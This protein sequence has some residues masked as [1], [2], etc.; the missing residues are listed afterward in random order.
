MEPQMN[1][2]DPTKVKVQ[3]SLNHNATF[4]SAAFEPDTGR[5]LAGGDDNAIHVFDPAD[6][7]KAAGKWTKHANY[8]SA[9]V[10]FKTGS[11]P[12]AVSGGYDRHLVWWDAKKGTAIRSVEAHQR[13]VRDLAAT[14]DGKVIVSVGDDMRVKLW[15][16]ASGKA[17]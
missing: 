5:L 15:D 10:C 6:I 14:P 7:K 13:W 4:L 9:L 2:I 3:A 1:A 16:A 8:V 17:I 11:G 12:V